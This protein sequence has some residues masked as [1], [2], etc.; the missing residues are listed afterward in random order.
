MS[1]SVLAMAVM[2]SGIKEEGTSLVVSAPGGRPS[3]WGTVIG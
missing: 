3:T 1:F 2:I